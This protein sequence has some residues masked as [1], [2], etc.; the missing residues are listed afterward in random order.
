MPYDP[1]ADAAAREE[2]AGPWAEAAE[3]AE[4]ELRARRAEA[5]AV[6]REECKDR[7]REDTAG[8]R[9]FEACKRARQEAFSI[10]HVQP[11]RI[12]APGCARANRWELDV[13][14]RPSGGSPRGYG[15]LLGG[16]GCRGRCE[17][18]GI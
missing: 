5:A 8:T 18:S 12:W 3:R 2:P 16:A 9:P 17:A 14:G 15:S 10:P 13:S 7:Q 11:P 1:G 4:A 6:E